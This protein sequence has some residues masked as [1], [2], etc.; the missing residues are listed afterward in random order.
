MKLCWTSR[1]S[2]VSRKNSYSFLFPHIPVLYHSCK[3]GVGRIEW[4]YR[5][6]NISQLI[7]SKQKGCGISAAFALQQM[8]ISLRYH[9]HHHHL[10]CDLQHPGKYRLPRIPILRRYL[11]VVI[12]FWNFNVII[13]RVIIIN[14]KKAGCLLSFY[15]GAFNSNICGCPG[16]F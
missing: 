4:S 12:Q 1:C 16:I 2:K 7:F 8:I 15:T 14:K 5:L 6:R 10:H 3:V 9:H 11:R 13:I